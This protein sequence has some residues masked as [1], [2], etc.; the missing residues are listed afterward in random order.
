MA[1]CLRGDPVRR[2]I[3]GG[4]E[5]AYPRKS[6]TFPDPEAGLASVEALFVASVVLGEEDATLLA[7]YP[8]AAAFLERNRE[9]LERLRE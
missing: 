2:S 6:K 3:P 7:G 8:F 9:A 4:I 5:T 1:R